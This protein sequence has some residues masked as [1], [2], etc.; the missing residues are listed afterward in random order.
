MM[1]HKKRDTMLS[2]AFAA[3]NPSPE[4]PT[5]PGTPLVM[6]QTNPNGRVH[7][8]LALVSHRFLVPNN[9]AYKSYRTSTS[10]YV[11]GFSQTY[12]IVPNANV[13][14]W[15]RRIMF[16][17]KDTFTTSAVLQSIGAEATAGSALSSL[18]M[19][20]LGNITTG[21]YNDLRNDVLGSLFAGT[22]GVDWVSPFR[23]KTDKTRVTVISDRSF[24]YAS[25]NDVAKPVI[26]K[27]YDSI[28]KTL[29]YDD[30]E[31][32]LSIIPAPTSVDSKLGIGNIFLADFYFC[33]APAVDEDTLTVSSQSTYYWHEK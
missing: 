13:C 26:R 17:T 22:G 2:A 14:W 31:N 3:E 11:K 8:T 30:E 23:A 9:A 6:N 16:A 20:D 5:T 25:G 15:H 27:M 28:N 18:P 19:V 32:G 10:T 33:P 21:P 4:S 12:T 24:N 29:V 1:A 7:F